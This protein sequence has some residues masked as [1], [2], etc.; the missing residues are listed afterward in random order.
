MLIGL[1]SDYLL[2]KRN[3][4]MKKNRSGKAAQ[5]VQQSHGLG[6]PP[7]SMVEPNYGL[8]SPFLGG[9]P[10]RRFVA[11]TVHADPRTV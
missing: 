6:N 2:E 3:K 5:F 1:T 9:Q 4:S 11:G 8:Y 7:V 10:A